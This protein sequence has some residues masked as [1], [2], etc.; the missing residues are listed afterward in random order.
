MQTVV[1]VQ[2]RSPRRLVWAGQ[3]IVYVDAPVRRT[4]GSG[5]ERIRVVDPVTGGESTIRVTGPHVIVEAVDA[6]DRWVAWVETT[7]QQDGA[8]GDA[9]WKIF[10]YE[11][12][13]GKSTL[14]R[15]SPFATP[16]PPYPIVA[17]GT[18]AWTAPVGLPGTGYDAYLTDLATLE[19]QRI[20]RNDLVGIGGL[21][22]QYVAFARTDEMRARSYDVNAYLYDRT[23]GKTRAL[24]T[25][26]KVEVVQIEG[27]VVMWTERIRAGYPRS[28][29]YVQGI[30]DDESRLLTVV[31]EAS[32]LL[33]R[34]YLVELD[35]LERP[36]VFDLNA[37]GSTQLRLP[38][39]YRR[40]PGFAA[41]ADID[42]NR[43]AWMGEGELGRA[44]IIAAL[45]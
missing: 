31:G 45:N 9:N 23:T 17:D 12:K 8:M 33:G 29:V 25:T 15:E 19:T 5:Y 41:A 36:R 7:D 4:G 43:L 44:I 21:T 6:D 26:G 30:D 10:R 14:V 2:A 35:F 20:I 16:T 39:G 34:G 28:R 18:L 22:E 27:D 24:T 37:V 32:V 42:G 1:P 3:R 13:T 38:A 40:R 11:L